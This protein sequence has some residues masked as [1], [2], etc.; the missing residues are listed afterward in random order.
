MCG[1]GV[2]QGLAGEAAVKAAVLALSDVMSACM[3]RGMETE[4][5]LPGGPESAVAA[6][7]S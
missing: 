6:P 5:I 3:E 7:T 1:L 4:G 2:A